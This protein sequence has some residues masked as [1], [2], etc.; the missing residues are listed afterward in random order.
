MI[1]NNLLVLMSH[2]LNMFLC[3]LVEV[4]YALAKIV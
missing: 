2:F 4:N 1:E 3:I